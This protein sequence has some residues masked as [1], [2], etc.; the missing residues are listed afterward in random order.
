[1]PTAVSGTLEFVQHIADGRVVQS[2]NLAVSIMPF[3]YE[4]DGHQYE[5]AGV[6]N[7]A[8]TD[9]ANN[10][11]Y[12]DH[13]G[14]LQ[15]TTAGWPDNTCIR[16]ALVTA[17]GGVITAI[18]NKRIFLVATL[19]KEITFENSEG[20][21]STTSTSWQQKLRL[22]TPDLPTGDYLVEW[23]CEI[24]HSNATQSEFIEARIE[25]GDTTEKGFSAW[26]FPAWDDFSG[27]AFAEGIS[28]VQTFDLDFRV[29]G[30]GTAY[31]RRARI[32]FRRI[33]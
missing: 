9:D 8:V 20:E 27:M 4:V 32:L 2:G 25:I 31:I 1:M 28:G 21:S 23:Y 19:D 17:S 26:A 15:V 16:L 29:Q 13:N 30:G 24:K 22:T 7:Q 11:I 14:T 33:Q 10:Y 12:I 5:Y 3:A 18:Q 6:T